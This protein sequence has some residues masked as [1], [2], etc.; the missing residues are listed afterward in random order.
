MSRKNELRRN[1]LPICLFVLSMMVLWL[2]QSNMNGAF[3]TTAFSA[4]DTCD[5]SQENQ[6][7]DDDNNSSKSLVNLEVETKEEKEA[8][9]R[10][11]TQEISST[12]SISGESGDG[13]RE[14]PSEHDTTIVINT[15]IIKEH[16][17]WNMLNDTIHSLRFLNGLPDDTP[18]VITIDGLSIEKDKQAYKKN[19]SLEN[20]E[21]LQEYAQSLRLHYKY[22]KHV[23]ILQA[24]VTGFVTNSMRM[25]MD[26]VDTKYILALQHDL[27]FIKEV[28]YSALIQSMKENPKELHTVAFANHKNQNPSQFYERKEGIKE[29]CCRGFKDEKNGLEFV[30]DRY[31]DHNHLT[32]KKYYEWMLDKVGPTGRFFEGPMLESDNWDIKEDCQTYGQWLY[33]P[34]ADGPY[35]RHLDGYGRHQNAD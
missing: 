14:T 32:T 8:G 21:R 23:T 26:F 1:T 29:Y 35:I 15:S 17:S 19:D 12:K 31:S 28:N 13:E 7:N 16:P 34:L 10:T 3:P 33:G 11:V 6:S 18:M 22:D 9:S 2:N 5:C 24:Y 25:A 27:I 30:L 20:K 4:R